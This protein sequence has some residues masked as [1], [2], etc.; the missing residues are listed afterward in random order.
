MTTMSSKNF[1]KGK[2]YNLSGIKMFPILKFC[3]G[4]G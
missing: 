4:D 2:R 1:K 3:G